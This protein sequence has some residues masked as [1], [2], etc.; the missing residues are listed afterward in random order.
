M[1]IELGPLT[2]AEGVNIGVISPNAPGEQR[3]VVARVYRLS[4]G[5]APSVQPL[6]EGVSR[7]GPWYLEAGQTGSHKPEIGEGFLGL[8]SRVWQAVNRFYK[9]GPDRVTYTEVP[10]TRV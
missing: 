10:P 2:K 6:P 5:I 4:G 8:E 9:V 3:Y 7:I 1:A